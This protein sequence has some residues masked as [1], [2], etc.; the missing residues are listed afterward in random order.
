[1]RY[2]YERRMTHRRKNGQNH[3]LRRYVGRNKPSMKVTEERKDD[4]RKRF[5]ESYE[6]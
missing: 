1:M 3:P 2:D 4:R 5:E 6:I